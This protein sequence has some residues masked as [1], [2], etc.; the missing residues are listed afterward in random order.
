MTH[1]RALRR[2]V[3]TRH[4]FALA[5]DLAFLRDPLHSII[6]PFLL[7]APWILAVSLVPYPGPGQ[8][9]A[10][11]VMALW[12]VATVGE[13]VV[14]WAV[15]AMLRFRARSVYN[16]PHGVAPAPVL[17]CYERGFARLPWLYATEFVRNLGLLVGFPMLVIPGI[18]LSYRLAFATEAVVLDDH[19]LASAFRHSY[20][21]SRGRIERWL[22]M[23]SGSVLLVLALWFVAALVY[24]VPSHA[25]PLRWVLGGFSLALFALLPV[26]QYAWTFFY[27][28]LTELERSPE[29]D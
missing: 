21:L 20:H 24:A 12:C 27:L 16:T 15:D 1:T 26:F 2:P 3:S 25:P 11:A 13:A 8:P 9:R 18:W 14:S 7:R 22:E 17:E 23:V 4:A 19:G 29:Q 6:V 5:L 10:R 28:R